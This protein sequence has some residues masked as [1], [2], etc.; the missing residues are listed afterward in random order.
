V[1]VGSKSTEIFYG[2]VIRPVL[3]SLLVDGRQNSGCSESKQTN[4][5]VRGSSRRAEG[6]EHSTPLFQFLLSVSMP[7]ESEKLG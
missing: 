5:K 6:I 3:E 7:N 4:I 2:L 1:K